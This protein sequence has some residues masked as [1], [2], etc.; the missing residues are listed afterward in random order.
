MVL[1]ESNREVG[2]LNDPPTVSIIAAVSPIALP[3][4]RIK[5]VKIPGLQHGRITFVIVCHFVAPKDK[6]PS[7]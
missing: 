7:R 1:V 3:I 6:L 2:T 5:P 4:P